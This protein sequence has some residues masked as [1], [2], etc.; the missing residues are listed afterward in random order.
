MAKRNSGLFSSDRIKRL[1]LF[2]AVVVGLFLLVDSIIMPWYVGHGSTRAVPSVSG[3][4]LERAMGVLDSAG[5]ESV[6][7]DTRPDPRAPEGTVIGQN[8]EPDAKVKEGRRVYLSVSGGEASVL[9]PRLRG[10]SIRDAK[11]SLER[12]GFKVGVLLHSPS[13]TFPVN[14]IMEQSPAPGGRLVKGSVVDMTVSAGSSIREITAPDLTGRTVGEAEK[15]LS[16]EG[17][18]LG[19]LTYQTGFELIPNTI[20]D[21]F[22]RPGDRV[23]AGD[24]VHLFVVRLTGL[25]DKNGQPEN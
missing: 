16:R 4:P 7:A 22:P 18:R 9:V 3:L 23:A 17:L 15:I 11:F 14:S 1:T 24:S 5:L 13:E 25:K 21:Q 8:P 20:V 10:L 19:K 2:V 6:R 12:A